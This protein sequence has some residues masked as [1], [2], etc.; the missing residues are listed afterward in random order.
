MIYN[1]EKTEHDSV[2]GTWKRFLGKKISFQNISTK[3]KICAVKIVI[4]AIPLVHNGNVRKVVQRK[5]GN[6][7]KIPLAS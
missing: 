2:I 6:S 3:Q 1:A 4:M 7:R 5:I